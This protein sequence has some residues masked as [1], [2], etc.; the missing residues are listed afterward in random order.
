ML[1]F[2]SLEGDLPEE[3]RMIMDTVREFVTDQIRPNIGEHFEHGTFPVDHIRTMGD[4]GLYGASLSGHGLPAVS[5]TANGLIMQELEAC[6]SGL[7]S[8]VSVQGSLVMYPILEYGSDTHRER[9][10]PELATGESVGCFAL[11]E[12]EHGSN[13]AGMATEATRDGDGYR[14]TGSKTWITNA[15]IADLV[16]VWARNRSEDGN[17]VS[18]FLVEPDRKG[19]SIE[20]IDEK[21]SMRVSSTGAIGLNDVWVPDSAVLPG[22]TGMKGPLSC[23]THARLGIV[24]GVV[25]AARDCFE[26]ALEYSMERKQFGRPIGGF[27]LQQGKLAEMATDITTAQLLAHRLATLKKRDDLR[28]Q[29]VSMGKLHNVR[30]CRKVARVAREMLGGNG[31]TH[32]YSPMR[33]LA[34]IETVYTYEG[35]D[36]IHALILGEDLT[37]IAAFE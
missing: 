2:L 19:V 32:D 30:M 21:L 11:T 35:T 34:N 20:N 24:W 14:I 25:G 9:W 15:P 28:H 33:H 12:P 16:L 23:L 4:L 1:D 18:G 17:P 36:D 26:T 13:P 31:I 29:H 6:D 37:G 8:M 5:D 7:R 27:Q 22:V 10:L 3:E